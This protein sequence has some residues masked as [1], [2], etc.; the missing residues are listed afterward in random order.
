METITLPK[1]DDWHCHLRDKLALPRTLSDTASQFA[2]AIVMPNLTPAVTTLAMAEDYYHRILKNVPK[3]CHFTPL[4]TLYLTDHTDKQTV[5]QAKQSNIIHAF[6]LYPAGA[7]TNSAAGVTNIEA[8]L[9]LLETFA[10]VG[11][12]LLIHGEVVD[13]DI[14]VFDREKVFIDRYLTKIIHHVPNLKI[15]LEHISTKYAVDFVLQ[16]SANVA[17]TIT[18]HHLYYNRNQLLVGGLKPDYYCLP[19]LKTEQDQQ[20]LIKAAISGNPK[21]FLGTDSAPHSIEKK[22]HACCAA[23][24]YSAPVALS[25]YAEVFEKQQAL[26]KLANFAS[27]YGADFYGLPYNTATITLIKSPWLVPAQLSYAHSFVTPM[28]ANDTL[29]WQVQ[30]LTYAR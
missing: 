20:S 21:F 24:I 12:P 29:S 13:H 10:E 5:L 6:K 27:K 23:G 14:D 30:G 25:V 2:R 1:P 22:H 8:L 16:Q 11:L 26:D 3:G 7:T 9:P 4:M 28:C 19:I 15:V 17:A 18:A